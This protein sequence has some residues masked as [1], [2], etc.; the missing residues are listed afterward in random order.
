MNIKTTIT[1]ISLAVLTSGCAIGPSPMTTSNGKQG[2]VITCDSGINKCYQ[3]ASK[4]CPNGYDIIEHSK[5]TST[6][7]PHYGEYPMIVN[8]EN[9]IIECK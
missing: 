5:K 8:I 3:R 2:Y 1:I 6:L 9:I 4:L 7:V